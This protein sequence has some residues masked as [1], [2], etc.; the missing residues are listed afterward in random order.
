PATECES[1]RHGLLLM[2]EGRTRQVE[3]HPIESEPLVR[4]REEPDPEAGVVMRLESTDLACFVGLL[5]AQDT[6]PEA[7]E[8]PGIVRVEAECLQSTDHRGGV[9]FL[10]RPSLIPNRQRG[11]TAPIVRRQP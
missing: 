9:S 4:H 11:S 10:P 1:L 3:V 8:T 2:L 6:G 5:P 7:R